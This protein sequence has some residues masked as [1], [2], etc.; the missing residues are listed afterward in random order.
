MPRL[1][2]RLPVSLHGAAAKA[3]LGLAV[4]CALFAIMS[5]LGFSETTETTGH[6]WWKETR[7]IPYGERRPYLLAGIGLAV[8]AASLLIGALELAVAQARRR[9]AHQRRLREAAEAQR[10]WELSPEGQAHRQAKEA[11]EARLLWEGSTAGKA[12]LAYRRGDHFFSI[13][14]VADGDLAQHLN[15]VTTAGWVQK[16]V[17]RR[18]TRTTSVQPMYDGTHEVTRDTVEYRTY[19]FR[20]DH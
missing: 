5:F 3:L 16:S 18:H 19:L 12:A 17:S 2:S 4:L 13:E 14:L 1:F 10:R 6:L 9:R 15:A 8:V 7:D 11:A 20:R